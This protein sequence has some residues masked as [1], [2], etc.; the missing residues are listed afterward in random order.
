MD[1]IRPNETCEP[2]PSAVRSAGI[3][4]RSF[5]SLLTLILFA[6]LAALPLT[7]CGGGSSDE[8][9]EVSSSDKKK[10]KS[11]KPREEEE[12][13]EEE[14]EKETKRAGGGGPTAQAREEALALQ[15]ECEEKGLD[16]KYKE[17]FDRA[18][19]RAKK[20]RAYFLDAD[21]RS[22]AKNY[23][24]R[25]SN[26]FKTLLANAEEAAGKTA[27]VEKAKK[28]ATT[29]K[30]KAD[31]AEAKVNA[32][33]YYEPAVEAYEEA[34]AQLEEASASSLSDAKRNFTDAREGF[35]DAALI[36][37]E[38]KQYRIL[39]EQLK[40]K[41]ESYKARAMEKG[42]DAKAL[43]RWQQAESMELTANA[44]MASGEFQQAGGQYTQAAQ[45]YTEALKSVLDE[46]AFQAEL[47]K[48]KEEQKAADVESARRRKEELELAAR[49]GPG[50]L[51]PPP[52]PGTAPPPPGTAPRPPGTGLPP[53][54]GIVATTLSPTCVAG[55]DPALFPQELDDEDEAFLIENLHELSSKAN[56]DPDTGGVILDYTN[57][58]ELGKEINKLRTSKAHVSF[59]DPQMLLGGTDIPDE[60]QI[61]MDG[62]TLGMVLFP[63]PFKY[64]VRMS[65]TFNILTMTGKGDWG[66]IVCSKKKSRYRTNFL[67]I[68]SIKG[69]SPPNWKKMQGKPGSTANYWHTK[70][71][72]VNWVVE[73]DMDKA[74]GGGELR[75]TYDVGGSDELA[76]R[77]KAKKLN[78]SGFVGF[79]WKDVKFRIRKL[80]I[81]GFLDKQ[82]AVRML[83]DKLGV[84]KEEGSKKEA[85]E[86]P[87]PD[88]TAPAD[89]GES[90]D[91]GEDKKKVDKK[92]VEDDDFD[93]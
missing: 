93:F 37:K 42:A 89:E 15:R 21:T 44:A 43:G 55:I 92:K 18:M 67:D 32:P 68:G 26:E 91:E 30:A 47:A 45:T 77:I 19:G 2:T 51:P 9:E 53:T 74:E 88:P 8:G 65:W 85:G 64:K 34:L 4:V 36:A 28:L 62:N 63:L 76:N 31:K 79:Q 70:T 27:A 75:A 90:E 83:R 50:R 81:C 80:K 72:P 5:L 82:E 3:G 71:R 6:L 25:A 66:A 38:N 87:E 24:K 23:Y 11:R 20:A 49:T 40:E 52:P 57:G 7:G 58:Q 60:A 33:D 29:A 10:K 84:K 12:E 1:F 54:G 14:E 86:E 39:A 22:K 46:A 35:E 69:S 59:V 56:Y 61:S 78:Q 13:E 41:M 17:D 16:K 48:I 73:L